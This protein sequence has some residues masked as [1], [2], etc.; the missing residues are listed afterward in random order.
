MKKI[1]ALLLAV[2]YMTTSS[3]VVLKVHYCMGRISSVE[4]D[5]FKDA[6]CKCGKQKSGAT[7][8][9]SEV[10]VL[11]NANDHRSTLA[12]FDLKLPPVD[13]P[14]PV[15]LSDL[16]YPNSTLP[17]NPSGHAPPGACCKS[18]IENCVFRI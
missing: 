6:F 18:Y 9:Q 10:K 8:C 1:L 16:Y 5:N 14:S 4:V 3:G 2:L 17:V 7:C 12:S 13:L 11:K 15:S